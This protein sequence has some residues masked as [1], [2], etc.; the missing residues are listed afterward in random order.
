VEF[1]GGE[2]LDVW[3]PARVTVTADAFEIRAASRV[4]WAWSSSGDAPT[5]QHR[6]VEEHRVEQGSVVATSTASARQRSFV[7]SPAHAAVELI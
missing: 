2:T 4:R 6:W 5:A 1:D 7:P 3:D